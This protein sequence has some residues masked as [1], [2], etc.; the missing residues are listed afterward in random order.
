MSSI[1]SARIEVELKKAPVLAGAFL[2]A[3]NILL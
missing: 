1:P 3:N 2:I